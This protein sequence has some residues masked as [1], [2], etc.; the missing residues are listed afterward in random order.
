MVYFLIGTP[1]KGNENGTVTEI[2]NQIGSNASV[3]KQINTEKE[4]FKSEGLDPL[5]HTNDQMLKI[6][7]AMEALLRKI[8]RQYLDITEKQKYDFKIKTQDGEVSLDHYFQNF[9]WDD[10]KFPRNVHMHDIVK[11][12]NQKMFVSDHS[13]R[14]KTTAYQ[15]AK[16][17]SAQ[18]SKKEGNLYTR[19]LVDVLKPPL[20][21]AKDFWYTDFIT[22][23]IAIVP[24]SQ[25]SEWKKQYESLSE[26]VV[27]NSAKQFGLEDK[28]GLVPW[29]VGFLR[30]PLYKKPLGDGDDVDPKQAAKKDL[31]PFE[32]F[33][34]K[35]REKLKVT[36]REF[37]FKS[38]EYDEKEKQRVNLNTEAQK[39]TYD[40]KME[41][42]TQFS[43]LYLTYV[44]L[45]VL[46]FNVDSA[47]RFGTGEPT[48]NLL[49]QP[50]ATK[51]KK[52]IG[53]L[54]K[55]FGDPSQIGLYGTKEELNETEDFFPFIYIPINV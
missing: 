22:T 49:I 47:L 23:L 40:L 41:C 39:K 31:T 4:K 52:V 36:I 26:N 32:A 24:K 16:N 6:D 37:E 44:H 13:I 15:D 29:R 8:E 12:L 1:I 55:M 18:V 5:M 28:D 54:L 35:A 33:A 34:L 48:A 43:E 20:A 27:P 21:S 42:E 7:I 25:E 17:A 51:E 30:I 10:A 46:R 14:T 53:V 38:N 11:T 2:R 19:D 45:K 3:L 9:R 50:Q